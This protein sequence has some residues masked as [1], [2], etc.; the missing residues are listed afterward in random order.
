MIEAMTIDRTG[1][2]LSSKTIDPAKCKFFIF[3]ADHYREDG[4]CK[5][6]DPEHRKMMIREWEYTPSQFKDIPLLKT[7]KTVQKYL[8]IVKSGKIE[9]REIITLRS[10]LNGGRGNWTKDEKAQVLAAVN[11]KELRLNPKQQEKGVNWLRRR[12]FKLDGGI[13][14][15]CPFE[16]NERKLL[17]PK[18]YKGFTMVGLHEED[19]GY[20]RK[21]YVP[22]YRLKG[23][24]GAKVDYAVDFRD[25]K[26]ITIF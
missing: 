13:R 8:D 11:G 7:R 14:K 3:S 22:I 17:D 21:F 15:N 23:K 1:K 16:E 18:E 4:T 25:R 10:L 6:N 5:C 2:V 19:N 12:C 9:E 20:G 26:G 24:S